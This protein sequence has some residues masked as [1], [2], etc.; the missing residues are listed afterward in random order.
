MSDRSMRVIMGSIQIVISATIFGMYFTALEAIRTYAH[1]DSFPVIG[2]FVLIFP[3]LLL[4]LTFGGGGYMIYQGATGRTGGDFNIMQT[5]EGQI[6]IFLG[7]TMFPIVLGS[8]YMMM[9][10]DNGTYTG[11]SQVVPIVVLVIFLTI[12]GGGGYMIFQGSGGKLRR[13]GSGGG[14]KKKKH[15]R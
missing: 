7:L 14:G 12:T 15:W 10:T 8:F 13:G 2:T 3:L 11:F 4:I 1:I 5:V 9:T 6:A